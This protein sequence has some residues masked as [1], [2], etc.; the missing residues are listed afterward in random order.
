MSR[1]R[2]TKRGVEMAKRD[3]AARK[4]ERKTLRQDGTEETEGAAGP[5]PTETELFESLRLLHER[6]EAGNMPFEEFEEQKQEL[7]ARLAGG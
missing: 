5:A 6:F 2:S 1:E 7:L 4:Q 3:K